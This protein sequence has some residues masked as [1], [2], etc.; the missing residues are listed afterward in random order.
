MNDKIHI[1]F[2]FFSGPLSYF[3]DLNH[4]DI[5]LLVEFEKYNIQY[6]LILTKDTEESP[7]FAKHVI[8]ILESLTTKKDP[9]KIKTD[10][11]EEKL[12]EYLERIKIKLRD[13]SFS[14]DALKRDSQ[15]IGS[16]LNKVY[17]DLKIEKENNEKFIK[18]YEEIKQKINL[19]FSISFN[20]VLERLSELQSYIEKSGF[21]SKNIFDTEKVKLKKEALIVIEESKDVSYFRKLFFNYYSKMEEKRKIMIEKIFSLYHCNKFIP[22]VEKILSEEKKMNIFIKMNLPKN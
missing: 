5:E 8:K 13:R 20:L 10:L 14:V 22:L 15:T 18:E 21:F 16:L 9:S 17:E 19:N 7:N 6:Y 3:R 1:V 2:M 12:I 4:S 11:K